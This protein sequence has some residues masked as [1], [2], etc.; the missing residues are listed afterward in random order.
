MLRTEIVVTPFAYLP[1]LER[2]GLALAIGLFVGLEPEHRRK[3]AGLRTFGCAALIGALGALLGPTYA[4]AS[5]G[6]LALIVALLNVQS[7]RAN[8]SLELT[9]S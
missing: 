2:L 8:Q 5:L 7:L 9:T 4:L 1:T 3:E 6:F